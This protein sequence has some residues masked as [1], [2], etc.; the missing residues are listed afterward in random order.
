MFLTE[1]NHAVHSAAGG[2]IRSYLKEI[3]FFKGA[4]SF[5]PGP[6]FSDTQNFRAKRKVF[7]IMT[8]IT[9]EEQT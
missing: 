5:V 7:I 8:F 2:P 9:K 1:G 4:Q 3:H 6:F